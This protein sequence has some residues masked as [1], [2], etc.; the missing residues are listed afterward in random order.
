MKKSDT[1]KLRKGERTALRILEVAEQL[2]AERGYKGTSL[3][4]IADQVGIKE[5][6]LYKY[7]ASKAALYEA[8]LEAALRPISDA[9]NNALSKVTNEKNLLSTP[10]LMIDLLAQHPYIPTLFQRALLA[11]NENTTTPMM[12]KW[13]DE[14]FRKGASL[15]E[16]QGHAEMNTK[17]AVAMMMI[18]FN[19]TIGYFSSRDWVS[20]LGGGDVLDLG[21]I[22]QQKELLQIVMKALVTR[23]N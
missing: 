4:D 13:L 1:S 19:L 23:N 5:P 2:F 7:F 10:S 14:L 11:D 20:K 18:F 22:E 16:Q 17:D 21:N 15:W 9:I 12:T 8:V 6:G 3:R